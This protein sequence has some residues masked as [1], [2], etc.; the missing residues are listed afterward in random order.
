[1]TQDENYPTKFTA[2]A[3]L[4]P[5]EL[6]FATNKFADFT[7]DFFFRGKDD[8]TAVLGGNDNKWNITEAGTYS[9]TIDVASKRVTITKPVRNAPTGISTVD[10][11]DEAPAEYFT[12]NGIKVTN[13]SSGIY[14]KRQGGKT[15]KVFVK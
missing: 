13:P 11:S 14:I 10:S 9:V 5:G 6:K 15:T 4:V 7:Q 3:N 8:Y 12:L 2:K 1:M